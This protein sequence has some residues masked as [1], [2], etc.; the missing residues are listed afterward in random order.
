M[1]IKIVPQPQDFSPMN[2]NAS[3]VMLGGASR[4]Q[5]ET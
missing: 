4:P 5:T 1:L 3:S 2:D